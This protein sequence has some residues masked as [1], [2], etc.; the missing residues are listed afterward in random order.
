M[1]FWQ[2]LAFTEVDQIVDLAGICERVGFHG[3]FVADHLYYPGRL[4]SRYPYSADGS[5]PFDS[6]TDWPEEVANTYRDEE[7]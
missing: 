4:D 1:Q 2:S 5:P 6:A 3:A 7:E